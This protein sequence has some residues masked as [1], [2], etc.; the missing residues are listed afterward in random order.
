MAWKPVYLFA[1]RNKVL[2]MFN[3]T[4]D[5]GM[6]SSIGLYADKGYDFELGSS[7]TWPRWQGGDYPAVVEYENFC[8][9]YSLEVHTQACPHSCTHRTSHTTHTNVNTTCMH[10][11]CA[12]TNICQT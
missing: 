1:V 9:R 8:A 10:A 12:V 3:T 5:F 6:E 2:N 11:N 4:C 7:D